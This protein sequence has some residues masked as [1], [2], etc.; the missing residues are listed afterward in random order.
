MPGD[1]F[2]P[3][4]NQL[5]GPRLTEAVLRGE[6]PQWRLDDMVVRIIAAYFK[7]HAGNYTARPDINFSS[8]TN[9]TMGYLHKSSK[10]GWTTVNRFVDVQ[11]DHAG[12]IRE[13]GAKSVVL[14]KNA[15][16]ALPL[17]APASLAVIGRDAHDDPG[18]PNACEER[19]CITGTVAMGYGSGTA[20]FPYLVSP[21]TALLRRAT[22]D[23]T[24]FVN[25]TG[26]WDLDAARAAARD[27][28]VA[29]VFAAATAGENFISVDGNFGDRNNLTLW[30]NGEALIRAVAS[31]NPN[32][33]VVLHTPG[34][35]DI[36]FAR[37]H[38]NVTAILWAGLPGQESGNALVDVLYGAS[39]P[40]GR[41]PFTWAR[42]PADYGAQLLFNASDPRNPRQT[43]DEGVFIDY[44]H[45]QRSAAVAPTFEFGFGLS[46]TTFGYANLRVTFVGNASVTPAQVIMQGST[47][48]APT[49]GTVN[50]SIA[51]HLAPAGFPKI[52]P[53]VYP[54]LLNVTTI[55]QTAT[56]PP[57]A[58]TNGS[59]QPILPAGGGPGGNPALYEVLYTISAEVTN[60]GAV[61][62]TEIPQLV[63]PP[64]YTPHVRIR[65]AD[66]LGFSTSSSAAR[67]TRSPFCG[68]S[69]RSPSRRARRGRSSLS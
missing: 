10:T 33:V 66:S 46:Y 64:L 63:K 28:A 69:T 62:G 25:T 16:G 19:A 14:L 11:A 53:Y 38:P 30:D 68:A 48:P 9:Q 12:V 3:P 34:P 65:Y 55:N 37:D 40:Q 61:A 26:N 49:Y 56:P 31:V 24:R 13:I 15:R 2:A 43:F 17:R 7:T 8:W 35:V 42:S 52:S 21:A 4:Y 58:M 60:T 18:G 22:A 27:A 23:G 50:R 57:T 6:V 20:N 1:N 41:S 47:A 44:R 5:W 36:E 29:V 54:W 32:T 39:N 51:A 59:S 67:I 45:F